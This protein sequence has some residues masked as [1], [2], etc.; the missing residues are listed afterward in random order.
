MSTFNEIKNYINSLPANSYVSRKT[1]WAISK[2]SALD[3][4][5]RCLTI[6]GVL[7]ET[8]KRGVYIKTKNI[9]NKICSGKRLID[10]AYNGKNV[11]YCLK[12]KF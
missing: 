6:L 2:S 11:R 7:E 10:A 12:L 3:N 4:Y 9:S 5:R 8:E 1:L